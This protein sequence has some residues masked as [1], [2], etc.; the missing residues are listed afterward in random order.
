MVSEGS[1]AS[2]PTTSLRR[3]PQGWLMAMAIS[4]G[5]GMS[6]SSPVQAQEA[7]NTLQNGGFESADLTI[8]TPTNTQFIKGD[9]MPSWTTN[10]PTN[11]FEVW[12]SPARPPRPTTPF[13]SITEQQAKSANDLFFPTGGGKY[14]VEVNAKNMDTISQVTTLKRNGLVS[15]SLWHQGRFGVDTLGFKIYKQENNNWVPV[16]SEVFKTGSIPPG[17]GWVNYTGKN[18]FLGQV[19][20]TYKVELQAIATANVSVQDGSPVNNNLDKGNLVDNVAFGFI[21]TPTPEVPPEI[22]PELPPDTVSPRNT[23]AAPAAAQRYYFN[24][25]ETLF[26]FHE[27]PQQIPLCNDLNLNPRSFKAANAE[28]PEPEPSPNC[29]CNN[30]KSSRGLFTFAADSREYYGYRTGLRAWAMGFTSNLNNLYNP[31]LD[32]RS[33]RADVRGAGGVVGLE[34][35]ITSTTQVGVYGSA[36]GLTVNQDGNGGGDWSPGMYG[37][38]LYGR[39]SPGPYFLAAQAGYGWFEGTQNRG[40]ELDSESMTATGYK[41]GQ[42]FNTGA[43]AG[44]RLRL[45]R[46]TLLT[47]SALL[48]WSSVYEAP[49]SESNAGVFN[50]PDLFNLN[51]AGHRTSWTT[52]DLGATLSRILRS[53]T[54]LIIPSLRVAYF[55]NWKTGGGNQEVD[56][57]FSSDNVSYAGGWMDRN[58]VRLALGVDV[59]THRNTSLFIKGIADIA[60]NGYG[61][62]VTDYGINGGLLVRF[63]GHRDKRTNAETCPVVAA[64]LPPAPEPAPPPPPA[65]IRGLW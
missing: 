15:Y 64:P 52:L 24:L 1:T 21:V 11:D 30:F 27:W 35:S 18:I 4:G 59:T 40:V 55:G 42:A 5:L 53:G 54:T 57:S 2:V 28:T 16:T 13:Y 12:T 26:N 47:P 29:S 31:S 32:D 43:S 44:V 22:L 14:F 9:K 51:Y 36:G 37:F 62:T 10:S 19:G 46:D 60:S 61:G 33:N 58:G 39:W 20:E 25:G 65:A 17:T 38:G 23:D 49:F 41:T 34:T 48:G 7:I 56:Y 3:L 45:S 8:T 50:A 6:V 63:G